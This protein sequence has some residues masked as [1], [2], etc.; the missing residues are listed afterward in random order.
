MMKGINDEVHA[1]R[2]VGC[3]SYLV[4]LGVNELSDAPSH[5]FAPL[6][7]FIPARVAFLHHLAIES[8]RRLKRL[9]QN[10]ARRRAIQIRHALSHRKVMSNALPIHKTV[11]SGQWS[12]VSWF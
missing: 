7:P 3:E 12:V 8:I 9:P 10:S 1:L 4:G 5:S 6:K 2:C 11:V